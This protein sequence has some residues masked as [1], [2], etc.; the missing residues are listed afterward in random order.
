MHYTGMG[1]NGD[2]DIHWAQN[3]TLANCNTN[4]V[5]VHLFRPVPENDVKKPS[6]F[7]FKDM[8]DYQKNGKNIDAKL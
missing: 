7:V 6:M 3:D 2:Q 8:E 1:K 4:G 5:D